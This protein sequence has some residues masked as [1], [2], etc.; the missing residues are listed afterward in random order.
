MNVSVASCKTKTGSYYTALPRPVFMKEMVFYPR[1]QSPYI[2][3]Y[4]EYAG[5][6]FPFGKMLREWIPYQEA[7]RYLT[8]Q[9]ERDKETK[10]DYRG[11]RFYDSDVSRF[12]SVDPLVGIYPSLSPYT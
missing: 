4:A 12:L 6:Y 3:Y 2:N 5:D 7:E 11:A 9:H 1:C 10:W 8:T